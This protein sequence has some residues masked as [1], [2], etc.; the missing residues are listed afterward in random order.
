MAMWK[1]VFKFTTYGFGFV[2]L[3]NRFLVRRIE[4]PEDRSN[5][6]HKNY[7]RSIACVDQ[8]WII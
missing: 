8:A 7:H 5:I 1:F 4:S 3:V 2:L 6:L